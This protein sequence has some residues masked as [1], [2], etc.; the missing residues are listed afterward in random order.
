MLVTIE[1]IDGTG[2]STL[3]KG[4]LEEL[5]DLNPVFT[6]E[7]GA[8]WIGEQVR[9]GIKERIDPVAEALLFV[10]D[11]AAHLDT[12]IKPALKNGR[13]VISDRYTDSRYAYQS[14]TLKGHIKDPM[15]WLIDIHNG[16]TIAP[17]I[18]FLLVVPVEESLNRIKAERTESEHFECK[19]VLE[20]VQKN[21]LMLAEKDSKRF[22]IIDATKN[23]EEILE[24]VSGIIRKMKI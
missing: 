23:R 15:K 24:F 22:V 20:N 6:R 18:T 21:Y 13:I 2:K 4:L 9:R 5:K 14:E 10:A 19:S 17:D 1:G 7:P 8:T 3:L 11:H 16:W 12:V